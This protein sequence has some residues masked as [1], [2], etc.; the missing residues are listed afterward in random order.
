MDSLPAFRAARLAALTADD[1]WLNLTD[2]I[3]LTP[4]THS[5]GAAPDNDLV[6]SAGP[7]HLGALTVTAGNHARLAIPGGYERPF[8]PH[9]DAYPRL[10]IAGLLLELHIVEGTPALRVRDLHSP[11][12]AAFPGLQSFPDDPAWII[13]ADWA[14]LPVP[15]KTGISM[16]GGRADVVTITHHATFVHDGQR[17]TLTPTHIKAGKPMFVIRDA[18][19]AHETYAASRFL[20]GE[21]MADGQITLD[22]NRAIN[23][24]CAFTDLAIC[25]LPPPGNILPFA[26]RAGEMR[27]ETPPQRA[28]L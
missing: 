13:R 21:D 26:I 14:A 6:L 12:R 15:V 28:P 25:P 9:P 4:G 7:G 1:G 5:V 3:D 11:Q 8:Q 27:P 23:P 16:V 17:V 24:P 19:S 20:I 22:F 2:R 10:Q 18:T